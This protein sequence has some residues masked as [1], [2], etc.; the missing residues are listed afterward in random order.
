MSARSETDNRVIAFLRVGPRYPGSI[1]R[2]CFDT[3]N[4][5]P[6]L[7]HLAR[8]KERGLVTES[9]SLWKLADSVRR[10]GEEPDLFS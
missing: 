2:H 7:A 4:A 5:R 10:E 9:G 8:M 3:T 6:A 1:A